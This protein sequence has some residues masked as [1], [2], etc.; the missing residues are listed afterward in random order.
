MPGSPTSTSCSIPNEAGHSRSSSAR[1]T[2]PWAWIVFR[3][4]PGT[5]EPGAWVIAAERNRGIA[6]RATRLLCSW[7]LQTPTGIERIQATVEPWNDASQRLLEKVGFVREGLLRSYASWRGNRQDVFVYS[8]LLTD[9]PGAR[10]V[11]GRS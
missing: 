9:P 4:P 2:S 8:L 6:E 1:R 10:H 7:A 5:A 11:P 3:H